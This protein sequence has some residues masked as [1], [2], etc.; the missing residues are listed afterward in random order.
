M[1]KGMLGGGGVYPKG[2][3]LC[4]YMKPKVWHCK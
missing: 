3:D 1:I 4:N 2:A